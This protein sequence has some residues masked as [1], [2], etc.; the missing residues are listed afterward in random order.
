VSRDVWR[1]RP[2]VRP[3]LADQARVIG[4]DVVVE[5]IDDPISVGSAAL[6]LGGVIEPLV[7]LSL[8]PALALDGGRPGE[9]ARALGADLLK[10]W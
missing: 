7:T 1:H 6:D 4:P 10:R 5:P 3:L 2:T 8:K 9:T